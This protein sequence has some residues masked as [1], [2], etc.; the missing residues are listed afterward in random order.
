M[1]REVVIGIDV[2]GVIM[3][4]VLLDFSPMMQCMNDWLGIRIKQIRLW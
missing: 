2:D 1:V 3:R 4:Q